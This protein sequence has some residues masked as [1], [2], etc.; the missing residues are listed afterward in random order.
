MNIKTLIN[1]FE[2]F[3]INH[4][5]LK[6][7]SWGNLSDYGREDYIIQYPAI[8]FVPQ[9]SSLGNT[10]TDM[11]FSVLVYDL[12]N[13]YVG[14]RINSNQLDSMALTQEILND[15]VNEFINQL[16]DFG[17]YLNMPIQFTPFVDKFKESVCGVEATITITIEQTACIP[18]FIQE[19]FYLLFE[20][21]GIFNSEN[22]DQILYQQQ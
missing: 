6:S 22:G 19:Q 10:S 2:I 15:F 5:I 4:P 3:T 11:T 16:T 9:P 7:F 1:Y 12:L 13:E 14:E 21:G 18:P 17:F 20:N 8:H